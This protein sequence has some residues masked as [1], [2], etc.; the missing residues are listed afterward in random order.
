MAVDKSVAVDR[1]CLLQC[2]HL[3]LAPEPSRR[4]LPLG[5]KSSPSSRSPFTIDSYT[6]IE[7]EVDE[8]RKRV[9]MIKHS[10]S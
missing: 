1:Y 3:L 9:W 5:E 4:P 7:Q 8:M 6:I 2:F 10:M